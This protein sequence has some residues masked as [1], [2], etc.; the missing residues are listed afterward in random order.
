MPPHSHVVDVDGDDTL[1]FYCGELPADEVISAT[2]HEPNGYFWE[3]AATYLDPTLAARLEL[4]SEAGMFSAA[5]ARAD[6]ETLQAKLE[7]LLSGEEDIRA[8]ISRAEA[9]G[10]EFDD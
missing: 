10:I 3:G 8:L 6:L 5:G 2:G 1:T 9:D 7:P 4:D